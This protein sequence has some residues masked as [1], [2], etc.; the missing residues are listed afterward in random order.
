MYDRSVGRIVQ[1]WNLSRA[2]VSHYKRVATISVP[3]VSGF[4]CIIYSY[5][6]LLKRSCY[7]CMN[8]IYLFQSDAESG[9]SGSFA[10]ANTTN[11]FSHVDSGAEAN[12]NNVQVQYPQGKGSQH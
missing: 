10:T 6:W 4:H 2:K 5:S 1:L 3:T 9:V 7:T 8:L 11:G 12:K